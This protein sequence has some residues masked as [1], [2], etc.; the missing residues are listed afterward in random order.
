MVAFD[1][2][3]P[4]LIATD[5]D[6]TLLTPEGLV[7]QRT[8]AALDAARAA[9]IHVIP[10][11]ARQPIGMVSI[12]PEAGFDSWALFSNGAF[13]VHALS[14]E[15]LFAS[16]TPVATLRLLSEQLNALLPGVKYAS[17]QDAGHGFVAQSGYAELSRFIDHKREPASM[18]GVP[19]AEVLSRPSLKLVMRHAEVSPRYIY[20]LLVGLKVPGVEITLSGA[21]FVEVMAENVTKATGLARVC[22]VLGVARHE[23]IAFGDARNDV[24]MLRWAGRGVAVANASD[25]A[26]AAA[27]HVAPPNSEDGVAH[28]IELMLAQGRERLY[29]FNEL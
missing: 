19:L 25:E 29:T 20:D 15:L 16:E 28:T 2:R 5:L 24:E 18:G 14:G 1:V 22:E 8:R 12:T 7:S 4:R 17:V 6:H 26:L 27:D 23:V 21:P 10:V 13:G 11:T 3:P 9:G